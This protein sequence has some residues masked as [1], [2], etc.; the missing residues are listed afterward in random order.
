MRTHA[1]I[2]TLSWDG[3]RVVCVCVHTAL[4]GLHSPLF[5]PF[6][7]CFDSPLAMAV[8]TAY[9]LRQRPVMRIFWKM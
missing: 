1:V 4:V 6:L 9:M 5:H 2:P 3:G 7:Q 8:Y